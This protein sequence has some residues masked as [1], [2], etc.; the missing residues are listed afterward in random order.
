MR[1]RHTTSEIQPLTQTSLNG[2]KNLADLLSRSGAY[3]VSYV[4]FVPR[5]TGLYTVVPAYQ[6]DCL[7]EGDVVYRTKEPRPKPKNN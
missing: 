5:K 3:A 6:K 4:V 7:G 1:K 2:G